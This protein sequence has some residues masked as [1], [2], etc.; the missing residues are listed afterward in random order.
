MEKKRILIVDDEKAVRV[1]MAAALKHDNYEIDLAENG[2][3]AI[4]NINE[5]MYDLIITDYQMPK[6]NG[7]ELTRKIK[8]KYPDTPILVVTGT[9]QAWDLLKREATACF[10][11]PYNLYDL[12][13][14]V[15]NILDGKR[16]DAQAHTGRSNRKAE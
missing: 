11:K 14:W 13:E 7:L 12:Q 2:I 15:K 9:E 5:T 4:G 16:K 3:Q 6:M 10:M 1:L 8:S